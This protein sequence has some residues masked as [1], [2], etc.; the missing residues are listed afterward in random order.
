[1]QLE[2]KGYIYILSLRERF[3][4]YLEFVL[5]SADMQARIALQP[6]HFSDLRSSYCQKKHDVSDDQVVSLPRTCDHR[7]AE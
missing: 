1:M 3:S 4:G 7:A 5:C 2:L 6:Y